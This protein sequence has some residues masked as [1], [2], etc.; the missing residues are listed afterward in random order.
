MNWKKKL[1]SCITITALAACISHIINKFIY[2][3]ATVDNR[4]GKRSGYYYDW[5]FG[6]IFY[7]KQGEGKPILLIHDLN[8]CSSE[9]E[10]KDITKELS[11]TNT[12]YTLDLLGC[13]KS[14]K[15][16]ITYTNFLYVQLITDFIK[17]IIGSQTDVVATGN[18]S[19]I[20]LMACKN[21]KNIIR[22]IMLVNPAS[23]SKL[24]KIPTKRKKMLKLFILFPVVGTLLYNI[25]HSKEQIEET[26][27][28][29]YFYAPHELDAEL[30]KVYHESAHN[31][32]MGSRY[33]FASIK[34][35]YT[36]ANIVGCLKQLDHSIFIL[37]GSGN[38]EYRKIAEEYQDYTPAI[39]IQEIEKTKYLPQLESPKAFIEQVKLLFEIEES[40]Q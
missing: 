24:A 3:M 9:Y 23:L 10:W 33:L 22:K 12:V 2:F 32:K 11:K 7:T 13:G 15:P 1:T 27:L 19:A 31:A 35:R 30:V 40:E 36:N 20:V 34:G 18:S 4:L 14:D 8:A 29:E 16:N 17:Q 38:P 25:L 5:R 21:D 28:T 37:V 26:Y 39:E 6:K